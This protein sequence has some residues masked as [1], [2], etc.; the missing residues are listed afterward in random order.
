M[1][2]IYACDPIIWIYILARKALKRKRECAN[3]EG[4]VWMLSQNM[5]RLH[6]CY[7]GGDD[8]WLSH[9]LCKYLVAYIFG[10]EELFRADIHL[11]VCVHMIT[12]Q[13]RL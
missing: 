10:I 7:R 5:V 12:Q 8:G 3:V 9:V 1:N 6:S 4:A 11:L 2:C 13:T